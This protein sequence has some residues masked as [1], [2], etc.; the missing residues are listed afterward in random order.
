ME[1]S[2]NTDSSRLAASNESVPARI[3]SGKY[4]F[5]KAEFSPLSE[6]QKRAAL[7]G[8]AALPRGGLT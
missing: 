7:R 6:K 3:P 2:H 1:Y 5:K 8:D 4:C